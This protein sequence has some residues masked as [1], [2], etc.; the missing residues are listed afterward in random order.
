MGKNSYKCPDC[1]KLVSE[2][3]K[4]CVHCGIKFDGDKKQIPFVKIDEPIYKRK[5]TLAP[6]PRYL[7]FKLRMNVIFSNSRLVVIYTMI[8]CLFLFYLAS[9]RSFL[10]WKY[11]SKGIKST[12]G[13]V[14]GT[15]AVYGDTMLVKAVKLSF[16]FSLPDGRVILSESFA[17]NSKLEKGSS[18]KIEYAI[19][20]PELSRI[21]GTFTVPPWDEHEDFFMYIILCLFITFY[22]LCIGI[23]QTRI[24]EYGDIT[25]GKLIYKKNGDLLK[26]NDT[27]TFSFT[28][29]DG[30]KYEHVEVTD[31][32]YENT[33]SIEDDIMERIIYLRVAPEDSLLLDQLPGKLEIYKDGNFYS[34]A[35]RIENI[36]MIFGVVVPV[37]L[38]AGIIIHFFIHF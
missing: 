30:K 2:K 27:V 34:S 1:C 7:S 12:S 8:F 24:L 25:M 31:I 19:K 36:R 9:N 23:K 10:Q 16:K 13:I 28:A 32:F 38:L 37:F 11:H 26:A 5:F 18:V 22:T 17:W 35:P 21:K 15:K 20:K 33:E 29:S 6:A 3:A 14:T 4:T